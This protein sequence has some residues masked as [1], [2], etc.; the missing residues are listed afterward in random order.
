MRKLAI[1]LVLFITACATTPE[2]PSEVKRLK[3]G[4]LLFIDK[5]GY[6][7]M[8]DPWGKSMSMANGVPMQMDDGSVIL[9]KNKKL[10]YPVPPGKSRPSGWK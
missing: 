2:P 6:M 4:S 9:M 10:R 7:T 1:I 8:V 3:N 5:S